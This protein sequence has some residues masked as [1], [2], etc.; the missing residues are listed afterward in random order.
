MVLVLEHDE[1][2][3]LGVVLNEPLEIEARGLLPGW[4]ERIAGPAVVFRGGPVQPEVAIGV[5]ATDDG[6]PLVVDL[7]SDGPGITRMR[8]FSGYSGWGPSQLDG[9]LASH[10][11]LV[12][13]AEPD[14][15][16]TGDPWALWREVVERLDGDGALLA[17]LP[18]DPR[19]N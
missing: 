8:L 17:T 13:P 14:D 4:D 18:M 6:P 15:A 16:F 19:L 1:D 11:W 9:E 2:G 7:E 10:D 12:V 5:G 3:A